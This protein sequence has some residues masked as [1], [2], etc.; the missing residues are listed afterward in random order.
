MTVEFVN[1][2]DVLVWEDPDGSLCSRRGT[3]ATATHGRDG[4]V[5][6]TWEDGGTTDAFLEELSHG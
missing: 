5:F 3:V 1:A 4:T 2:G 6:I